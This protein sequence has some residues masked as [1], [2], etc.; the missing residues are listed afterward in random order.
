MR[1]ENQQMDTILKLLLEKTGTDLT[2]YRRPALL[3]RISQ[4]LDRL[5]MDT[6]QY[7]SVCRGNSDECQELINTIAINVSSFFRDTGVFETIAQTVLPP[8]AAKKR[9][10]RI[11]SAGCAAG[12]E[13]YSIAIQILGVLK[14]PQDTDL[15]PLIFGTDIDHKTL[16][17]AKRA[18]YPRASLQ[19]TKLG[20][21]D[22]CF[23]AVGNR[24]E[25][26]DSI[27]KTVQFSVNDLLSRQTSAP[28][29]SIF[30]SFDIILCRNVLIYFSAKHK[31]L[32]QEKLY[33]SLV[34]G[35]YLILGDSEQL[36]GALKPRFKT[37]NARNKIYQ[38]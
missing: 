25:L 28:A 17:K 34:N 3:R 15:S 29:D 5:G 6:D 32:V 20:I 26:R 19:N 12:E 18:S 36:C 11:W 37:I 9:K 21:V 31:V 27:K 22:T 13:P 2:G 35:G 14:E 4:R 10:L 33:K 7:L 16:K 24:F 8:L 1:I 38:K 30:G 23:N